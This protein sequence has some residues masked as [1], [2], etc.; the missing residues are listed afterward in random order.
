MAQ[1]LMVDGLSGN[2]AGAVLAALL[3]CRELP[4]FGLPHTADGMYSTVMMT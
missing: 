1:A 3:V 4:L 2:K